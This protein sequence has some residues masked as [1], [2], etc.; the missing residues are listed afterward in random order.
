MAL[1]NIEIVKSHVVQVEAENQE[2]A[3]KAVAQMT[4]VEVKSA[5]VDY[6]QKRHVREVTTD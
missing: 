5:V 4:D 3:K 2:E 1:Y 6:W